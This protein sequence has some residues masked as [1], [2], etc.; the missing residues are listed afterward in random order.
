M[1]NNF[2]LKYVHINTYTHTC[3]HQLC[4]R[5]YALWLLQLYALC[6]SFASLCAPVLGAMQPYKCSGFSMC[7]CL[8]LVA[9]YDGLVVLGPTQ[10][11]FIIWSSSVG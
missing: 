9:S 5:P 7:V 10:I 1:V 2:T 3:E 8:S 4:T 11:S 6:S